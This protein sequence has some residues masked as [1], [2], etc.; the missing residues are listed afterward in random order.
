[1]SEKPPARTIG[2]VGI[3]SQESVG[4]Q[5]PHDA[6]VGS[7]S[8]FGEPFGD[9]RDMLVAA[10]K[11]PYADL[12]PSYICSDIFPRK[13]EVMRE[14]PEATSVFEI[15]SFFGH[16]LLTALAACPKIRHV[17]WA[18]VELDSPGS[19]Q[20][21]RKNIEWW[22]AANLD[23][24]DSV[25]M[26]WSLYAYQMANFL[27]WQW[28]RHDGVDI[29]HVDGCHTKEAAIADITLGLTLKPKLLLVDDTA[30][31]AHIGVLE[32][33]KFAQWNTGVDYELFDT[34]NGFA[35]FRP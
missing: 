7:S 14:F 9:V 25:K 29:V 8:Y 30:A 23:A 19:N 6:P 32:A 16:F 21:V 18:D 4:A 31:H 27:H 17:F 1:M 3:G 11:Q 12:A 2:V 5:F 34:V 24:S 15:G 13:L 28:G 20:W 22:S 26:N 33:V 10:P 35:A